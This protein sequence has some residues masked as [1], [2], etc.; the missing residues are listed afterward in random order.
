MLNLDNLDAGLSVGFAVIGADVAT[1]SID[2][3]ANAFHNAVNAAADIELLQKSMASLASVE[4][5]NRGKF[6]DIKAAYSTAQAYAES[7]YQTQALAAAQSPF[8]LDDISGALKTASAYGFLATQIESVQKARELDLLTAQRVSQVALDV[9]AGTGQS[10]TVVGEIVSILGKASASVRY[11]SEDMNQLTDRMINVPD[12][13]SKAWGKPV[14]EIKEMQ[15]A[16][17]LLASDVNAVIV[18]ALEKMYGGSAEKA[19]ETISGRLATFSDAMMFRS[20]DTFEPMI[21]TLGDGLAELNNSLLSDDAIA[22]AQKLGA[23]LK[24]VTESAIDTTGTLV[25]IGSALSDGIVP[26]LYGAATAWGVYTAAQVQAQVTAAGGWIPAIALGLH[27]IQMTALATH[28]ALIGFATTFGAIAAA[29]TSVTAVGIAAHGYNEKI[30]NTG[31]ALAQSTAGWQ[32]STDAIEAYNAA[33]PETRKVLEG[34]YTALVRLSEAN[35]EATQQDFDNAARVFRM[36][37]SQAEA[38]QVTTENIKVRNAL[39]EQRA[40]ILTQ[41]V[42][43]LEKINDAELRN[44]VL[45]G[46]ITQQQAERL[47]VLQ[48]LAK[49]R[50][51][52][53]D[54]EVAFQQAIYDLDVERYQKE[55]DAWTT[56]RDARDTAQTAYD[57]AELAAKTAHDEAIANLWEETH[58]SLIDRA[59]SYHARLADIRRT[60]ADKELAQINEHNEATANLRL[61]GPRNHLSVR[62]L[63]TGI[64]ER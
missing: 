9:V 3:V 56:Y 25:A 29:A 2:A 64:E 53:I 30:T 32:A 17:K 11:L 46:K 19:G 45:Q 31:T 6:S 34:Q 51:S 18:P 23:T 24:S 1:Q 27:R 49:T 14:A 7:F 22:S 59:L 33:S 38:I 35:A 21:K 20:L 4:L 41:Q 28:G 36:G 52:L 47:D 39:E 15:A 5:V 54:E 37:Q 43:E 62:I 40:A 12:L 58:M 50:D 61:A 48:G 63:M 13:L 8:S 26:A 16:G 44:Q 10:G 42:A 55:A 57:N 60:Y